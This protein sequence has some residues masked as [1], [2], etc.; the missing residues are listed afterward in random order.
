MA[1]ADAEAICIHGPMQAMSDA[2]AHMQPP[3]QRAGS[4]A[5]RNAGPTLEHTDGD[6]TES[7]PP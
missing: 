4:A 7:D 6:V 2:L 1:S 5:T 3:E